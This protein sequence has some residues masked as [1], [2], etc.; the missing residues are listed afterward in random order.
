MSEIL[1]T[2]FGDIEY[3][4]VGSGKPVLVLHG[5]HSNCEETLSLKGLDPQKFQMTVPSRPGYGSTP[6]A[7]N[8]TPE[9]AA[10]LMIKLLD[11]LSLDKVV[12]YGVSAGGLTA[13]ELAA[14]YPER[15][16]KLVLASA[17]SKNWLNESS[18]KYK[19]SKL[20]F[21]PKNQQ[22]T[23]DVVRFLCK[24]F[25][26]LT[27]K[28]FHSGFSK[29]R[30][31]KLGDEEVKELVAA[32]DQ[33]NSGEGFSSDIDQQIERHTIKRISC[34]TLI[35]HSR[36]DKTVSLAHAV[37]A[38]TMVSNSHLEVVENHWGHMLWIGE[39]SKPVIDKIVEFIDS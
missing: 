13:I 1:N 27:A 3:R 7:D 38:N 34:P 30:T 5:G 19:L 24:K 16:S 8:Q 12:V 35:I 2:E 22:K 32:V 37:Y 18:R 36:Y 9:Q 25:P 31:P 10:R 6:L 33:L 29:A 39:D 11:H 21:S 14:N 17:V 4:L 20:I 26:K 15:V 28:M 23:W